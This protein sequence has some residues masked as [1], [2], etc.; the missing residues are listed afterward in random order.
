MTILDSRYR[1]PNE[2]TPQPRGEFGL[3]VRLDGNEA[4]VSANYSAW[5][6]ATLLRRSARIDLLWANNAT[7]LPLLDRSLEQSLQEMAEA[8]I[9]YVDLRINYDQPEL[10]ALA[11]RHNFHAVELLQIYEATSPLATE[12][13]INP[14]PLTLL[15]EQQRAELV[16]LAGKA[17]THSRL[18]RDPAIP[19]DIADTFYETL[20][21]SVLCQ[22]GTIGQFL[23]A[24]DGGVAGFVIGALEADSSGKAVLWTIAVRPDLKGKGLGSQL[25]THF[26]NDLVAKGYSV[27]IGTQTDNRPARALYDKHHI[28]V[29]AQLLTFH[30]HRHPWPPRSLK[31]DSAKR[32]FSPDSISKEYDASASNE[33]EFEKVKWGSKESMENRFH[34]AIEKLP[35]ESSTRWLD[36][37]CG[38]GRFQALAAARF[39]QLQIVGIDISPELLE[40][41]Q[42]SNSAPTIQFIHTDLMQFSAPPFDLITCIGVLQKTSFDIEQFFSRARLLLRSGGMLMI[43][44]KNRTWDRFAESGFVPEASMEW[45]D[46]TEIKAAAERAGFR[47]HEMLGFIPAE[48]QVVPLNG[49]HSFYLIAERL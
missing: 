8:K 21:T 10:I 16:L 9:E 42:S 25:L 41:A 33:Q 36:I 6:T 27:E 49:S 26:V 44:T 22:P 19:R 47:P 39:P 37:G 30:R 13:T 29:T 45:F 40:Y 35:F 3:A 24:E 38:T 18:Y 7:A 32:V 34:L 20:V 23:P 46:P 2:E 17:F 4:V 48:G 11:Q 43:D 31:V 1:R 14:S 28:P 12:I 15:S 5:D